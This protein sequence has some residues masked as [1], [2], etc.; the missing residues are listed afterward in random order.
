MR[1]PQAIRGRYH[2]ICVWISFDQGTSLR[3]KLSWYA[4][5]SGVCV[6]IETRYN[7]LTVR[8]TRLFMLYISVTYTIIIQDVSVIF[9]GNE[10]TIRHICCLSPLVLYHCN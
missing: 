1:V 5:M 10:N 3:S 8:S 4:N 9:I 6:N 7:R 2:Q